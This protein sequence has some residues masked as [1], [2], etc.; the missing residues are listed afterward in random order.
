VGPLSL[1]SW[2]LT[3]LAVSLLWVISG[4]FLLADMCDKAS[5]ASVLSFPGPDNAGEQ[6]GSLGN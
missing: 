2:D 6:G 3:V 5:I 1:Y 4:F